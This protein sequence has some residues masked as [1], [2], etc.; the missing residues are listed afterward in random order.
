VLPPAT[1]GRQRSALQGV[2]RAA[3]LGG[4]PVRNSHNPQKPR[5]E[6]NDNFAD[7]VDFVR[8]SME[9]PGTDL[10]PSRNQPGH[11][12]GA[13]RRAGRTLLAE[14]TWRV[15]GTVTA[16]TRP[17][18]PG[19]P[20]NSDAGQC[21]VGLG[22]DHPFTLAAALNLAIIL[23]TN[24]DYAAATE[25]DTQT[26]ARLEAA[27][28]A[29][30]P[31]TL[32]AKSGVAS[33]AS[34]AGDHERAA[35]ISAEV[36]AASVDIRGES[37]PAGDRDIHSTVDC[38]RGRQPPGP[39]ARSRGRAA[40]GEAYRGYASRMTLGGQAPLTGLVGEARI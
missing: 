13:A 4:E 24:G 8:A 26:A 9:G 5:L 35:R 31:H 20:P 3:R 23:R 30:H 36:Y 40:A 38:R 11:L 6:I 1:G 16:S 25:L 28:G 29:R 15:P 22:H 14:I 39:C 10:A 2:A 34:L 21:L 19:R 12:T 27:L 18:L 37:H 32:S 33:N 7:F 17:S